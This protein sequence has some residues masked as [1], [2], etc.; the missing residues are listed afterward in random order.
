VQIVDVATGKHLRSISGHQE[1]VCDL[2]FTADGNYVLSTGRD[3][4]L[5]I[6]Q[7]SD[8]KEVAKLGKARGGQFKDWFHAVA[9]SADQQWIATADI[10]GRVFVWKMG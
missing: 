7:V 6:C 8:G 4:T 9:L 10:S 1:G 3:T 5:R 2:T